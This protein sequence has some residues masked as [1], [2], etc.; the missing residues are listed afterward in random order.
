[1]KKK[2]ISPKRLFL[3]VYHSAHFEPISDLWS[4]LHLM[5][6]TWNLWFSNVLRG[7]RVTIAWHAL[8][9]GV[10]GLLSYHL[11]KT[12]HSLV[13]HFII[14]LK[15]RYLIG[16]SKLTHVIGA[17]KFKYVISASKFRYVTDASKLMY[18]IGASKIEV[19]DWWYTSIEVL[20]Y[21]NT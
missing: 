16:A 4:F 2:A 9:K 15:L 5:K 3:L 12:L 19:C 10:G 18:V 14:P 13:H 11:F 20:R 21:S 7:V 6:T 17:S 8:I 1:M